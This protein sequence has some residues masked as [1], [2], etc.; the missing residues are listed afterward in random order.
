MEKLLHLILGHELGKPYIWGGKNPITSWDCSGLT[1]YWLESVGF[2][3]PGESN[4]QTLYNLFL[5]QGVTSG[6][7][8]GALVFFGQHS[9][10]ITHVAVLIN[11][12]LMIEAGHGDSSCTTTAIAAHK[13]AYVRVRPYTRRSDLVGILMPAYP[14]WILNA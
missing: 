13:G 1:E 3:M 6:A 14:D 5:S 7:Q 9:K 12:I 10:A 11:P 2:E 4:A 8:A